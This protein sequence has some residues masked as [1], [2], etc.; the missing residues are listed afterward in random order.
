MKAEALKKELEAGEDI[1]ILDV[2]EPEEFNGAETL[3]GAKNM[4]VA[5]VLLEAEKGNLSKNKK[6]I[7]LCKSGV[8]CELVASELRA[9]GYDIESLEGGIPAWNAVSEKIIAVG[10]IA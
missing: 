4:P 5:K 8:R 6:I 10:D 7:T 1:T 9:Q 2:R 3:P